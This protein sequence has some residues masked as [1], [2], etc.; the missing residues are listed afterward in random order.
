MHVEA[1]KPRVGIFVTVAY[2]DSLALG[3]AVLGFCVSVFFIIVMILR[4]SGDLLPTLNL[5]RKAN[6]SLG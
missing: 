6:A 3:H 5:L 1:I 2:K 4:P